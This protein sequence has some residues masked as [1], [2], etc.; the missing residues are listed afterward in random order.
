MRF[1]SLR[2]LIR[3]GFRN[4]GQNIFMSLASVG[5]L[6]SC[7]LITGS[8]YLGFANI[9]KACDWAYGQNVVVA[10]AKA[11][12]TGDQIRQLQD[13]IKGIT[14]VESVQFISKQETLLKYKDTI[15]E[16]TYQDMQGDN[17][18]FLDSYVITFKDLSLFNQTVQQIQQIPGIDSMSYNQSIADMLT[19]VRHIIL[20][21]GGSLIGL[22]FLV[23]IFIIIYT[24]KLTVYNR[25]LEISIM[26]SVGATNA[27]VRT[28]FVI[29]GMV[30]G[31]AA[32]LLAYG[33]IYV[34]Y[35]FVS[36]MF[37]FGMFQG[38]IDFSTVWQPV[39]LGFL[40]IGILTGVIGSAIS[41]GKYLKEEGGISRVL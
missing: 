5:I 33:L 12:C 38:L 16:A 39:L 28:P 40:A 31:L 7:L 6:I 22:L 4:I 29:E 18:P 15:P 14:N 27:F 10:F 30:L 36:P 32:A 8:A 23:S 25:R 26:K 3:E 37:H 41:I 13:K 2:Y 34:I 24:I 21:V 20:G 19:K 9:Q 11:D 1:S 17:N 35:L